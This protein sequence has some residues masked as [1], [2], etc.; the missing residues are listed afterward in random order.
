MTMFVGRLRSTIFLGRGR[1]A[2]SISKPPIAMSAISSSSI[3]FPQ[4]PAAAPSRTRSTG[5]SGR[6]PACRSQACR[7]WLPSSADC[8]GQPEGRGAAPCHL[9]PR[10]PPEQHRVGRLWRRRRRS[11]WLRRH[12]GPSLQSQHRGWPCHDQRPGCRQ[13]HIKLV[14]PLRSLLGRRQPAGLASIRVWI[15]AKTVS[16]ADETRRPAR[17]PQRRSPPDGGCRQA[18]GDDLQRGDHILDNWLC[19]TRPAIPSSMRFSRFSRS[20]SNRTSPRPTA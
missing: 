12:A 1:E 15:S 16:P 4:A 6:I 13:A 5:P 2:I 8:P 9:R 11:G 10:P 17:H 3:S 14:E 19:W 18:V 20:L 7:Q